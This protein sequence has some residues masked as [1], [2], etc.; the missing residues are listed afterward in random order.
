MKKALCFV[1]VETTGLNSAIHEIIEISIVKICPKKGTSTYTT[2]IQPEN[3]QHASETA[4]K[5]NGYN[6]RDWEHAPAA[7]SVVFYISDMIAG[8]TLVGHN[9]RFDEDF[10]SEL[11]HLYGVKKRYDRRLIDTI[12]LAHEQ[13][14]NLHSLSLD[15]IRDYF[16]WD[17]K[18]AHTA[19]VDTMDCMR[20]YYKLLRA[21]AF[22]RTC[23]MIKH[24]VISLFRR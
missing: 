7:Q 14:P 18:N 22:H 10:I 19:Y 20:L 8:C 21:N 9:I 1:D 6:Q 13:L 3:L 2:K 17:K 23:W 4:L 11:F 16:F 5:I 15:S 12:T 24:K